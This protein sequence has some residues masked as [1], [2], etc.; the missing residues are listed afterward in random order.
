MLKTKDGYEWVWYYKKIW[1]WIP[2]IKHL[3]QL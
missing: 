3:I 1:K 2:A